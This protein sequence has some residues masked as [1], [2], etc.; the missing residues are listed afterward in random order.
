MK[1]QLLLVEWQT[2]HQAPVVQR[3]GSTNKQTSAFKIN[4]VLWWMMIHRLFEQ[5]G[6]DYESICHIT[7]LQNRCYRGPCVGYYIRVICLYWNSYYCSEV[8]INHLLGKRQQRDINFP[9]GPETSWESISNSIPLFFTSCPSSSDLRLVLAWQA[10]SRWTT[11]CLHQ[12]EM[13]L[14]QY[15]NW[16]HNTK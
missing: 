15:W 12:S 3:V 1:Y 8:F 11:P 2:Q 5:I 4:R 10:V 7:S 9:F 13:L 14:S 16:M 6:T